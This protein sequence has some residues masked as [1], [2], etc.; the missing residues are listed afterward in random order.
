MSTILM[1][2]K[3]LQVDVSVTWI[4]SNQEDQVLMIHFWTDM[5]QEELYQLLL[6]NFDILC[7]V[8]WLELLSAN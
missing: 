4:T 1:I 6:S 3:Q 5:I 7:F 2:L 8:L